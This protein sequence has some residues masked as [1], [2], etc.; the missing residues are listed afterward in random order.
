MSQFLARSIDPNQTD[1]LLEVVT[2]QI[3]LLTFDETDE[4]MLMQ[5]VNCLADPREIVQTQLATT[6][7][8]IGEASTLVLLDGLANH[9]I[10][11]VRRGCG[12]SL[13]KV[14]DPEAVPGLIQSLLQDPDPR[15]KSAVSSALVSI[16][17]ASVPDLLELIASD[18]GT[19]ETGHAAWALAHMDAESLPIFYTAIDSPVGSVRAAVVAATSAI[20]KAHSGQTIEQAIALILISLTDLDPI[21][22]TE[23]ATAIGSIPLKIEVEKLLA[24]LADP[25]EDVRRAGAIA[26]GKLGNP[27][28][29]GLLKQSAEFD[30]SN[31]VRILATL[32]IGLL[33]S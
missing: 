13:A 20:L 21:V 8:E 12:R 29:I 28:A 18:I 6:F 14:R 11:L 19:A 24:T 31:S 25:V 23:A 27:S 30:E 33:E 3:T 4:D 7:G 15:V 10:A 1:A 22:R 17:S 9:P 5:L 32:A 26:L 2:Q 16:G